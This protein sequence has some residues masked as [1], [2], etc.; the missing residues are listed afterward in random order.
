M[1]HLLRLLVLLP[2]I[3]SVLGCASVHVDPPPVVDPELPRVDAR[4][5]AVSGAAPWVVPPTVTPPARA[6]EACLAAGGELVELDSVDNNDSAD[7][8]ALLTLGIS[9]SGVLGVAGEDGTLK[10]WTL[11]AE[12]LASVDGSVLTYGSEEGRT[13][14]TDLQFLDDVAIAGDVRGLVAHVAADG[15]YWPLGGTMPDVPIRSVAVHAATQRF[16]HTQLGTIDAPDVAPLVVRDMEE[17]VTVE[18]ATTLELPNDLAFA[19]SG[20]LLVAGADG[21]GPQIEIRSAADPGT[22][23]D[24]FGFHGSTPIVEIA[25]AQA[26]TI[27][28]AISAQYIYLLEGLE[29]AAELWIPEHAGRSVDVTPGG[30]FVLSVGADGM[31]L[32]HDPAEPTEVARVEVPD[33][34]TVRVDA[35]G[36]AVIVGSRDAIVHVFG[37][38]E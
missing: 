37:C 2:A 28:A 33:P 11:D 17:G 36:T 13:P 14:I 35:T 3:M 15:S 29:V 32:A 19:P 7:H 22:V 4:G 24:S 26:G 10:F 18:I 38:V 5:H 12:L 16:A 25:H 27:A 9:P 1:E 31:L 20:E 6:L 23:V 34:V 21:G 30:A 8:G